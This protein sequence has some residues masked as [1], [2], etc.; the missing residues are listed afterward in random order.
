MKYCAYPPCNNPV[1]GSRTYC[2]KTCSNK[3]MKKS[4]PKK[5]AKKGLVNVLNVNANT[6]LRQGEIDILVQQLT[7]QKEQKK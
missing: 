4:F 2:S 7:T 3:D 6:R 1:S 5:S